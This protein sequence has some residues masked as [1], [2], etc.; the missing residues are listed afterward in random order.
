M[1]IICRSLNIKSA[2]AISREN[3]FLR[4]KFDTQVYTS[5]VFL[6]YYSSMQIIESAAVCHA[7]IRDITFLIVAA[8]S[9]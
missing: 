9:N 1:P 4:T 7:I 6:G 2:G 8:F 3:D 5:P